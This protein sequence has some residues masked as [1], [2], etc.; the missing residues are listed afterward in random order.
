M[1]NRMHLTDLGR[2]HCNSG[3][4][5]E[6]HV[7]GSG[8]PVIIIYSDIILS[9]HETSSGP[10]LPSLER[11]PRKTSA[12]M[13]SYLVI[14]VR[15]EPRAK[16][17]WQP[18]TVWAARDHRR[19]KTQISGQ[20]SPNS[21]YPNLRAAGSWSLVLWDSVCKIFPSCSWLSTLALSKGH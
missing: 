19:D 11:E 16:H 8:S 15:K 20:L 17:E 21:G 4:R 12:K 14:C 5:G 18:W 10:Y 13:S 2:A 6:V 1:K 7:W 9:Y 3:A